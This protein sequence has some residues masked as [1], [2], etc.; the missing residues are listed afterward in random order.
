MTRLLGTTSGWESGTVEEVGATWQQGTVTG[1]VVTS[2]PTPAT[3]TYCY[4]ALLGA[5]NVVGYNRML[6]TGTQTDIWFR[7]RMNIHLSTNELIAN[8]HMLIRFIDTAGT[9][10]GRLVYDPTTGVLR[11]ITGG[12]LSNVIS[13]TVIGSSSISVALD[14]WVLVEVHY[15][16]TTG[17][18]GTV[19]I[20]I[21]GVRV[22]NATG[23]VTSAGLA[24]V[25]LIGVGLFRNSTIGTSG[26]YVA[27]DDLA[28][29]NTAGSVNNGRPGDYRVAW[30][31]PNGAGA[32][33]GW[34]PLA[35]SN[36]QCV[37][38]IPPDAADYVSTAVA[39]TI[40]D[41]AMGNL[42]AT[43]LTVPYVEAVALGKN[44]D[45]GGGQLK[46][47]VIS[48]ATTDAGTAQPLTVA[49]RFVRTAYELNPNGS[50]AWT[51][52]TVDA[53]KLRIESSA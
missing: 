18:T 27:Y 25:A 14:T 52:T 15:I 51:K 31:V 34:T 33:S 16:P 13:G 47:G 21:D 17:A 50:I 29:N 44:L 26:T 32:S 39:G 36:Y 30:L 20:W 43:A 40:D 11:F 53:A 10:I 3:G 4:K 22:L 7:A 2:S 24:N 42:P 38:E 5:A 9:L 45:G 37:D 28:V 19:E 48:G 6:S 12:T 35:G 46:V 41:Y 8:A 23:V 1:S 49:D